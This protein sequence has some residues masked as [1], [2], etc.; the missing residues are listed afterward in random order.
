MILTH[1]PWFMRKVNGSIA[2]SFGPIYFYEYDRPT[3]NVFLKSYIYIYFF[4]SIKSN[5][6]IKREE[7]YIFFFMFSD[8]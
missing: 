5:W 1:S 3:R 6:E 4:Y 8:T 7:N 2:E